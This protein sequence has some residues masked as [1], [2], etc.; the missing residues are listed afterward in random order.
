MCRPPRLAGRDDATA[1][2]TADDH[3]DA[4]LGAKGR[5][6]DHGT[7]QLQTLAPAASTASGSVTNPAPRFATTSS[8]RR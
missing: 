8:I 6:P 7:T 4:T 5:P 3:V 1:A 2:D